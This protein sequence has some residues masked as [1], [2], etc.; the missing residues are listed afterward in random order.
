MISVLNKDNSYSFDI[1]L[2]VSENQRTH[3]K[4]FSAN[5]FLINVFYLTFIVVWQYLV[6][7]I[8]FFLK[9]CLHILD[10]WQKV[11]QEGTRKRYY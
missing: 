5:F 2:F 7:L 11:R 8:L 1:F 3:W 9:M 6:S 10:L 4:F